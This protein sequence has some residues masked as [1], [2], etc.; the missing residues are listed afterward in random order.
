VIAHTSG[1][2]PH[3]LTSVFEINGFTAMKWREHL[4]LPLRS[5]TINGAHLC[6]TQVL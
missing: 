4:S 2:C 6:Q 5:D 1:L 3:S